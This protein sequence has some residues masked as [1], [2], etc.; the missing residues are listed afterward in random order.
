M[1][2]FS[3]RVYYQDT[4]AGGIVYHSKYLDFGERA[5][6]EMLFEMGIPVTKLLERGVAFV[7]RHVDIEYKKPARLDDLLTVRTQVLETKNASMV[8]EHRFTRGVE[9][10][11]II[12]LQLA[13]INPDTMTPVRMPPDVK[14][15]FLTY[16]KGE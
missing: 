7:L 9:E 15:K 2:Q 5:R 8:M 1:H 4:D 3:I 12:R 16:S 6:A 11:V 13:F 10:L 14:E